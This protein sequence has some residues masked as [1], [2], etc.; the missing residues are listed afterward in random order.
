MK[1]SELNMT[2]EQNAAFVAAGNQLRALR[3]QKGLSQEK[4][5]AQAGVDQSR[6]S[7]VERLGPQQFNWTGLI[8]VAE[9]LDCVMEINFRFK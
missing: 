3:E 8:R 7:K 6:L 2:A 9:A 1:I 4:L 5:A